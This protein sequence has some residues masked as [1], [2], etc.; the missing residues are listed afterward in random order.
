MATIMAA[1]GMALASIMACIM[2]TPLPIM[3]GGAV[4]TMGALITGA[5]IMATTTA[6]TEDIIAADVTTSAFQVVLFF[7]SMGLLGYLL[8]TILWPERF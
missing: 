7:L 5:T 3:L 8:A 2:T 1:I 6:G 4:T